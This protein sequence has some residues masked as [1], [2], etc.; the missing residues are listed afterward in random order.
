MEAID[1][2][3]KRNFMTDHKGNVFRN[4]K[5]RSLKYGLLPTTVCKRLRLGWSLEKALTT[6]VE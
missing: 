1:D 3:A 4:Q 2:Y 6:P 5:E